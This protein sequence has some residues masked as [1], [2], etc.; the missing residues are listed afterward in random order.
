M[1]S[2]GEEWSVT[3]AT[4]SLVGSVGRGKARQAGSVF[5]TLKLAMNASLGGQRDFHGIPKPLARLPAG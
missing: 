2:E 4:L 3:V 1:D 5:V